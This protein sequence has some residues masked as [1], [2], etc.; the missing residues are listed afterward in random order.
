MSTEYVWFICYRIDDTLE[1]KVRV[2]GPRKLANL[3]REVA[4]MFRQDRPGDDALDGLWVCE[5]NPEQADVIRHLK[6]GK[7]LDTF[8]ACK[9]HLKNPSMMAR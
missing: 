2:I 1:M 7:P 6:S 5:Q 8:A 9:Q 3:A 4:E